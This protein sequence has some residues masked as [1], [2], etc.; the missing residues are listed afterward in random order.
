MRVKIDG[1]KPVYEVK[2]QVC[3][4]ILEYQQYDIA[5]VLHIPDPRLNFRCVECP[6]C[7]YRITDIIDEIK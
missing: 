7:M 5:T 1:R 3:N 4:S 6:I 2:C